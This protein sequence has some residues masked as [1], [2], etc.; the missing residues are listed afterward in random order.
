[1]CNANIETVRRA[2]ERMCAGRTSTL[3]TAVRNGDEV[4]FTTHFNGK[5]FKDTIKT[6][7]FRDA[8]SRALAK[9]R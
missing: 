4:H 2:T 8:Y 5:T 9:Q 1:M 3:T 7:R 6:S